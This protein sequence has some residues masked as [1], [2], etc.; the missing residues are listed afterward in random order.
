MRQLMQDRLLALEAQMH[1]LSGTRTLGTGPLVLPDDDQPAVQQ[2]QRGLEARRVQ[3]R[4]PSHRARSNTTASPIW[5]SKP[6][7]ESARMSERI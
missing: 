2:G 3:A 7:P 5:G 6:A 4:I 1:P